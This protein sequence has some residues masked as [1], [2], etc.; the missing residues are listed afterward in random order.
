MGPRQQK[1]DHESLPWH[2]AIN[3]PDMA[4]IKAQEKGATSTHVPAKSGLCGDERA[5]WLHG[6]S[7]RDES[8]VASEIPRLQA[9]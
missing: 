4:L 3:A 6:S 1:D 2:D 5:G 8:A 7:G 9:G